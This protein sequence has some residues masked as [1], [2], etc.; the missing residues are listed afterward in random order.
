MKNSSKLISLVGLIVASVTLPFASNASEY[1]T[2]G[3]RYSACK[4]QV[5]AQ[6]DDVKRIKSRGI[7]VRQGVFH[8]KMK[9]TPANGGES[10]LVSCTID[11]SDVVTIT[12][13]GDGCGSQ[14]TATE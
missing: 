10:S 13:L 4:A 9:V 1:T 14:L 7:K 8:S 2:D 11:K 3:Q 12:C 5:F 6:F